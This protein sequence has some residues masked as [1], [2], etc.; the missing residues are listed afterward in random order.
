MITLN[1]TPTEAATLLNLLVAN[2]GM[3]AVATKLVRQKHKMPEVPTELPLIATL[4][5]AVK[6]LD[7]SVTQ[8]IAAIKA[9]RAA[10]GLGLADSKWA[11]ENWDR[12][13]AFVKAAGRLPEQNI[14]AVGLR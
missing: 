7:Y 12:F 6:G 1:L 13:I 3:A 11:I 9:V 4:K 2:G 5:E 8:K 14:A 10:T